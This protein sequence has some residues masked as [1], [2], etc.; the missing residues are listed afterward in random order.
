MALDCAP[1]FKY[2]EWLGGG[3]LDRNLTYRVVAGLLTCEGVG[4]PELAQRYF[5]SGDPNLPEKLTVYNSGRSL[6]LPKTGRAETLSNVL[7]QA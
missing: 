2:P 4:A 7:W 1:E 3:Y 6:D 5:G